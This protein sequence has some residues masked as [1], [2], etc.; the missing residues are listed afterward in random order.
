MAKDLISVIVPCYNEEEALSLFYKEINKVSKEFTTVDL[1]FIFVNDGS[2]DK[3]LEEIKKLAKKDKRVKYI[4]FSRN[5]G[6]EAAMMAGLEKSKGDYV[7]LMDADLQDPP[8]LLPEMYRI[9]KEEDYDQV[10]TRRV[11]RKGEPPI[12]S[13]FARCFYKLINK[14]SKV[15]MVDG[16]RDYRLMSRQVVD[17]IVSLQEYNRYSKG[18]FSFVGFKTK[19]LEYENIQR[20]AG[21]TKWSFWKLFIYAIEGIVAFTTVPLSIA[22]FLGILICFIAFIFIIVIIIKT[23]AFGDPVG[24]WPSM[25]CILLFVSGIQL[26]C[27]GIIGQYLAKTYLET[28]KR[29]VYII[30]ETEEDLNK[31]KNKA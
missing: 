16:A 4:S 14:M 15:E 25:V 26:L 10:G 30:K 19:W 18:L 11:N 23:L 22:A 27:M 2:K 29:P 13:F 7:T 20:V 8:S 21:E 1:E 5:F 9:I 28:K 6:K 3:T 31:D 12:R 24:G 17:A